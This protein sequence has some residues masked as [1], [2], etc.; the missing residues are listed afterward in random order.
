MQSLDL[1]MQYEAW[2][3]VQMGRFNF[4]EWTIIRSLKSTV[5]LWEITTHTILYYNVPNSNSHYCRKISN[6]FAAFFLCG[7]ILYH[8]L[9]LNVVMVAVNVVRL[10]TWFTWT[11]SGL[12]TLYV[13]HVKTVR[14]WY[15]YQNMTQHTRILPNIEF[16]VY[17]WSNRTLQSSRSYA[18][19]LFTTHSFP[20]KKTTQ[21]PNEQRPKKMCYWNVTR[22]KFWSSHAVLVTGLNENP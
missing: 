4:I 18:H 15:R 11:I 7:K 16:F 3:T 12:S 8:K 20:K 19:P 17:V 2:W 6:F 14:S 5:W 10:F 1:Y 9:V 21:K 13:W 22:N